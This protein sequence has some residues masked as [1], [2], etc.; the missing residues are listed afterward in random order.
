MILAHFPLYTKSIHTKLTQILSE[1][2]AVFVFVTEAGAMKDRCTYVYMYIPTY[3]PYR[4][5]EQ[6]GIH[7]DKLS[8]IHARTHAH[9]HMHTRTHK[10]IQTY[11]PLILCTLY[12]CMQYCAK[13]L[14]MT[15]YGV[16]YLLV[17]TSNDNH[18]LFG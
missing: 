6:S 10:H 8:H 2:R 14:T 5:S 17:M 4:D 13:E 1:K 15:K 9:T 3:I 12:L 7:T 18:C 16:F 11:K